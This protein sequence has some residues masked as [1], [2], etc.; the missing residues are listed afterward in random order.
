MKVD[1]AVP[2]P[3]DS[4]ATTDY[5]LGIDI[6]DGGGGV[7]SSSERT[8]ATTMTAPASGVSSA[9]KSLRRVNTFQGMNEEEQRNIISLRYRA[10]RFASV[11]VQYSSVDDMPR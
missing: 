9:P 5:H 7:P 2:S 10:D 6:N 8:A 3:S 4:S 1:F 11:F